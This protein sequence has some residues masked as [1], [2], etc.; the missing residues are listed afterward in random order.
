MITINIDGQ[1]LKAR[2]GQTI[3]QVAQDNGIDIPIL[4][5]HESLLPYKA[6]GLCG[7]EILREGRSHIVSSCLYPVKQGLEVRTRSPRAL[8][9]QKK[10]MM[11]LLTKCPQNK[12][13]KRLASEMGV[14]QPSPQPNPLEHNDCILCGVC[15]RACEKVV[16]VNA[17]TM[18][19]QKVDSEVALPSLQISPD[20]IGCGTCAYACPTR[21]IKMTD[22][23]NTRVIQ[24]PNWTMQFELKKCTACGNYWAPQAQ[25]E[26]IRKES[27]LPADFFDV[28]PNCR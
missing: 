17:I 27:N 26:H 21:A 9:N 25:L 13:I 6:C 7:V 19:S 1:E 23:R 16:G 28:C 20:C 4:C 2:E 12:V 15:V 5:Y 3:L 14:E 22:E 24:W 18:T 11:A 10:I 8:S